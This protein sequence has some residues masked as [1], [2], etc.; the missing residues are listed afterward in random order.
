VKYDIAII[1]AG[2]AG[3]TAALLASKDFDTLVIDAGSNGEYRPSSGVFPDHNNFGFEPIPDHVFARDHLTMCYM[4]YEGKKGIVAGAEFGRRL[5]KILFLPQYLKY[6]IGQAERKTCTFFFQTKVT[7]IQ[8]EE[9][10]VRI[11]CFNREGIQEFHSNVVFLATGGNDFQL[12]SQLGFRVPRVHQAIQAEFQ[13]DESEWSEWEAEYTFHVYSKI[14]QTGPFWITRRVGEFNVG[15]IDKA[16]SVEKFRNILERHKPIRSV[17]EGA[18]PL[19]VEGKNSHIFVANIAADATRELVKDRALVLG[20]AAGMATPFYYEGVGQARY[21]AL[22]AVELMR[23]LEEANRPPI[24]ENL[25]PYQERVQRD[26]TNK[27]YKSSVGS[28]T[29]FLENASM[30]TIFSSYVNAI[31]KYKDVREKIVFAYWNNPVN[32][33]FSNDTDVG[34]KIYEDLPLGKKITLLPLFL[35]ASFQ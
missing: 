8:I 30:D 6:A 13:K 34:R 22:Y 28:R 21:S 5:G 31:N 2:P 17:L 26:L 27:L 1:G 32:Y 3:A 16:V 35:K 33:R 25:L 19:Q 10:G 11:S 20:D 24:R 14:S 18:T 23:V 15:Y 7:R 9:D 4:D 29:I 12:H